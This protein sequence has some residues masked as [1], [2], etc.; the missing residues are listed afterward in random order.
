MKYLLILLAFL[1]LLSGA[2]AEDA[3]ASKASADSIK[4][5]MKAT[6][7]DTLSAKSTR[8][9][10]TDLK[11]L[12]PLAPAS[13][14]TEFESDSLLAE[15]LDANI[16]TYQKQLSQSEVD[17]ALAFFQSPAGQDYLQVQRQLA[18]ALQVW[19]KALAER[20]LQKYKAKHQNPNLLTP[21][22][23]KAKA[24]SAPAQ[25]PAP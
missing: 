22:A 4:Q 6:H 23:Q 17:A 18:P 11:A 10:I 3:K 8:Q 14:W 25:Q 1:G 24:Q 15:A 16:P 9:L 7:I 20:V 13:F 5:L 21:K 12:M 2:N 19:Q